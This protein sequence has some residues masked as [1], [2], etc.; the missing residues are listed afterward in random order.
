MYRLTLKSREQ[1]S[2]FGA[3]LGRICEPGDVICL[4]GDLGSGKTT[5]TQAIAHGIGV[6]KREYVTSPSFSIFHH[7][8]GK[9]DLYHMDFY[10]LES[11]ED[12]LALGI[13]EYFYLNGVTV[14]EWF[15]KTPEIIPT[16][17]LIIELRYK[18]EDSR[19]IIMSSSAGKWKERMKLL[20]ESA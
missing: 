19:D 3:A 5:L 9:L 11:S 8:P 6:D 7:Y 2:V 18:N 20:K 14:I 15:E 13:D 4:K 10:R 16:V 12:V 17:H 1:T